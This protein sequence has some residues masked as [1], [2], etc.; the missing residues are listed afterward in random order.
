MFL[1]LFD[2]IFSQLFK[3]L[4]FIEGKVAS[5]TYADLKTYQFLDNPQHVALGA[6]QLSPMMKLP[7]FR[8][9]NQLKKRLKMSQL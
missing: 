1:D 8:L 5:L 6:D 2:Y 7:R 3:E 9:Q 4:I